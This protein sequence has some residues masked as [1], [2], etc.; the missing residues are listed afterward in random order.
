MLTLYNAISSDGFIA[1]KTGN[2]DFIPDEAWSS[3]LGLCGDYKTLIIGRKTYEVIQAYDSELLVPFEAL[4]IKKIV[5][6]SNPSFQIKDGYLVT[7][8]PEEALKIDPEA[9]VC[10]GPTLNN[11]L[12]KKGFVKKVIFHE[13]PTK[14]E[15]GITPF[16]V[17]YLSSVPIEKR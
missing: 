3:F 4:P 12:L 15:N 1:D 13:I 8:S 2:E 16:D 14:I 6:S 10:S 17:T 5:I 11:A 9:L 7:H